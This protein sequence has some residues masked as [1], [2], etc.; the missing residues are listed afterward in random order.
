MAYTKTNWQDRVVEFPNRYAKSD[1]TA[2][3][4]TLTQSPGT[5]TQA[6]TPL[7]AGNMNKI[8]QGIA[9]AHANAAAA[10]TAADNANAN[11]NTRLKKD[12]SEAMTGPLT[13]HAANGT[14]QFKAGT[15]DGASYTLY[16]LLLKLWWGMGIAG[17]DDTV[18]MFFDARVGKIDVKNGFYVDG[19]PVYHTG[20]KPVILEGIYTSSDT[21]T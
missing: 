16:N 5:V 8:E 19:Q 15:G 6:G 11:A 12:G 14:N 4:I 3:E 10:Q 13:L 18:R 17:N 21:A 2:S 7:N 20:K 9:D 1:E